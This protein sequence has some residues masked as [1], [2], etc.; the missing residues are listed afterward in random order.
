[1]IPPLV[2]P[3]YPARECVVILWYFLAST[4]NIAMDRNE[5]ASKRA[6]IKPEKGRSQRLLERSF[7]W[8]ALFVITLII[9]GSLVLF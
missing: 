9:L 4:T 7:D 6:I 8:I 5:Y 1:M 2:K 3:I